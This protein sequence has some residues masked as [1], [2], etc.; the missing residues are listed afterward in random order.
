MIEQ[1]VFQVVLNDINGPAFLKSR[2][3][4]LFGIYGNIKFENQNITTSV[5]EFLYNCLNDQ[6]V[7][8]KYSLPKINIINSKNPKFQ[9]QTNQKLVLNP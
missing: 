3:A 7:S 5:I 9:I 8:Q 1:Y 4:R 2:I 6:N